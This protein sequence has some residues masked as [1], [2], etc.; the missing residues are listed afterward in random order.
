M[1]VDILGTKYKVIFA[2]EEERPYL[3]GVDGYMDHSIK[4]IVVGR[5]KK[6]PMSIGDLNSYTK[7]VLRHEIIHAFLYESGLWNNSGDVEAWAQSEEMTDWFSIQF[8]KILR[9][10][11]EVKAI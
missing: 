9:A 10:F 11:Q 5:F 4:E 7:K 2:T 8:P 6:G 3:N 1:K